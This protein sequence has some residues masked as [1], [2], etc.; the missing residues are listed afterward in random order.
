MS[1]GRSRR[2][3]SAYLR[4]K[5]TGKEGV[6]HEFVSDQTSDAHHRGAAV[7][8]LNRSLSELGL[9]VKFVPYNER[10]HERK[11]VSVSCSA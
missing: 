5:S 11:Y 6:A 8:E 1:D 3:N 7:V 4:K 9:V 2:T 10:K